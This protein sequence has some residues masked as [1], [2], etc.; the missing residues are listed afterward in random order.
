MGISGLFKLEGKVALVTGAGRGLGAAFCEA[1]AEAGADVIGSDILPVVEET[2]EAMKKFGRKSL[3]VKADVTKEEEVV[4]MVKKSISEFGRIDILFNNAGISPA[5]QPVHEI[6]TED[7]NK[8]IS[9]NLT[10]VFLCCR[11]VLKHMVKQKQGKIINIASVYGLVGGS[12][13]LAVPAYNASKGAVV[14]LTR[15]LAMEYV[16]EGINVNAIAPG[17]F[18]TGL[19]GF[20]ESDPAM[21][22]ALEQQ[23]PMGKVGL[24]ED[25]K[26]TALYLASSASDLVTGHTLVVDAGW[27]A[28]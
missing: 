11:E 6:S 26:G 28:S 18:R 14:N 5:P 13:L 4:E 17:F 8:V 23:I 16:K 20:A 2:M 22:T 24:P 3:A 15:E 25:L 7:W 9:I 12:P 10:G 1:M 21:F 27:I 19:G